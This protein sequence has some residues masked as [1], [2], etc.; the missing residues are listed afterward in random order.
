MTILVGLFAATATIVTAGFGVTMLLVR[1]RLTI[2]E[3]CALAW[4]FGTVA[5]SLS[6]WVS[7]FFLHGIALQI[8]V[9]GICVVIGALGFQRWRTAP[10]Q[11]KIRLTKAEI[12]FITLFVIELILMFWLSFQRDLGWDGLLAWEIKARY[13]FLNGGVLPVEFFRDP[14]RWFSNPHYPLCLPLTETWFYLWIGNCDQFW[15]KFIFPFWYGAAMSIMLLA[16]EEQSENRL[17]GWMIA[18][19]FLLIPCIHD[20]P[21]GFQVGYADG[22]LSA[23]YLGAAF[24]LLRFIRSGSTDAMVLFIALGAA[25]PCMKLEGVVLWATI[26]VCGAVAIRQRR[27][28]WTAAALSFLPGLCLIALWRVF[29]TS[30][31]CLPAQDFVFPTFGVLFRNIQRTGVIV[32]ELF[33]QLIGWHDWNIFWLLLAMAMIA[34]LARARNARAATL[35]CLFIV[36]LVCYCACYFFSAVPDYIWHMEVSLRRLLIHLVPIAWLLI[37]LAF[38]TRTLR[39]CIVQ[40]SFYHL[41]KNKLSFGKNTYSYRCRGRPT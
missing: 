21:G 2:W 20:L 23:I 14:S 1:H 5:V 36:P 31:H 17:V 3:T 16:A 35:I 41:L 19:L 40:E 33:L 28:A 7:G 30:V 9:T 34:V 10:G 11:Q 8:A 15:I 39:N 18:L 4:L 12:V 38:N 6:L 22:P 26:S 13:A 25:L 37:A 29:L 24:Y 32:H 27:R